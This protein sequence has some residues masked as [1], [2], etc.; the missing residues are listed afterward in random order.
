MHKD[1]IF[2]SQ[3]LAR[4]IWKNYALLIWHLVQDHKKMK[5]TGRKIFN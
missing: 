2:V 1:Q 4:K 5:L 3:M